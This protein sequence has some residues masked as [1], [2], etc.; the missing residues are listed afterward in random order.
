MGGLGRALA[1]G[2]AAEGARTALLGRG[3]AGVEAVAREIEQS[4]PSAEE[5]LALKCDVTDEAAVAEAVS[6]IDRRWGRID[7]L[8]SNAGLMLPREKSWDC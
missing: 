1:L 6:A 3:L 7:A 4:V 8:V 2:L 5:P